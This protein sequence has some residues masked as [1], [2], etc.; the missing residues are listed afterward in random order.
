MVLQVFKKIK[1]LDH[2][3]IMKLDYFVEKD[4][5]FVVRSYDDDYVMKNCKY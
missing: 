1:E 4:T 2:P 3:N 5:I